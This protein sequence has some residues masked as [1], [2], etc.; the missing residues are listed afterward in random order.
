MYMYET[1]ITNR[2]YTFNSFS[3]FS[4]FVY[5]CSQSEKVVSHIQ[6]RCHVIICM[7]II[8]SLYDTAI[9]D[10]H[11]LSQIIRKPVNADTIKKKS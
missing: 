6:N 9:M 8:I 10:Y 11:H 2:W 3:S 5:G 4:C 7:T 1:E